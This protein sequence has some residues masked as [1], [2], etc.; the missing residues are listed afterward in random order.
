MIKDN[1]KGKIGT[2]ITDGRLIQKLNMYKVSD[3]KFI[4]FYFSIFRKQY[5]YGLL[6]LDIFICP[7]VTFY[8]LNKY[9]IIPKS[10]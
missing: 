1:I 2:L 7:K 9:R 10:F 5:F 6:F 3:K 4:K 8:C